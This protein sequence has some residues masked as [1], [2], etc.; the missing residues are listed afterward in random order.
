MIQ[1]CRCGQYMGIVPPVGEI[2]VTRGFCQN[3]RREYAPG[4]KPGKTSSFVTGVAGFSAFT[5]D[6]R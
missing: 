2:S 1:V 4:I 6:R 3:C 5:L